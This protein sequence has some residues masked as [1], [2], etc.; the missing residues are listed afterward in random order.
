VVLQI[1]PQKVIIWEE[2]RVSERKTKSL[3]VLAETMTLAENSSAHT[4]RRHCASLVTPEMVIYGR[5]DFA[6]VR[7]QPEYDMGET[8][9]YALIH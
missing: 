9:R 1:A 6:I 8:R 3:F 2:N 5:I 4:F 7:G